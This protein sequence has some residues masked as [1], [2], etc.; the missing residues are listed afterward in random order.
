[1]SAQSERV[2]PELDSLRA[3][4]AIGVVVVH[5]H[6]RWGHWMWSFVDLFFVLSGFLITKILISVPSEKRISLK[7]FWIRRV[8]R[9][10]PVYYIALLGCC[11]LIPAMSYL[12]PGQ[13]WDWSQILRSWFFLQ[14]LEGYWDTEKNLVEG[15]VPFFFHSWSVAVEEQF[16]VFWPLLILAAFNR[17]LLMGVL[18]ALTALTLWMRLEGYSI[19][20]LLSR[21]DGL[22]WGALLAFLLAESPTSFLRKLL[23]PLL[24]VAG[25][26]GL[27]GAWDYLWAGYEQ[28]KG[29]DR[30]YLISAF[31]M[32]YFS[33][34]G[35]TILNSGHFLLGF[36]RLAW[37][38][39]LGLLSYAIYMFH[40]PVQNVVY[41]FYKKIFDYEGILWDL[42][43]WPILLLLAH[44]SN[45]LIES[46]MRQVKHRYPVYI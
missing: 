45:V 11:L 34:I 18:V 12:A 32:L 27:W 16:Y 24:I 36:L 38:R 8:L 25:I 2:I 15:F 26:L 30:S 42:T 4:A 17:F 3:I 23:Y 5:T 20:L 31:S 7:N 43:F 10:W 39:Y 14:N 19:Y 1:M 28:V 22:A 21:M 40:G 41:L 44:L 46:R 13:Q 33:V 37:L 9:I 29:A 35:L 6:A